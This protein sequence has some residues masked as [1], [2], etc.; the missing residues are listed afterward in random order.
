MDAIYQSPYFSIGLCILAFW[1]GL[2]IQNK[3]KSPLCNAMVL[4]VAFVI[5]VLNVLNISYDTFYI[6]GE[7]VNAFLVPAT[8]CLG[9]RIYKQMTLLKANL[10]PVL[11]G[12]IVGSA[13]SV[14]SVLA[15]CKFF[16]LDRAMTVSLLPKSV[17][18][19]IAQAIA[20]GNGGMVPIAV[21]AVCVTGIGGN[22]LAPLFIKLFRVK[23]PLAV[24][25]AIGASSHALGTAKALQIGE[26]EG[27]M[28]GLAMGLCG[29]FTAVL[30]L[31]FP[32]IV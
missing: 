19:P 20:D 15:L 1:L 10:L 28:S 5:I 7:M 13:T 18:T 14:F 11:V 24:G 4:A 3:T 29:V 22:L 8:A 32:Y 26:T 9:V 17:T 23:D 6:G 31:L 25:L 16:A 2:Q 27:A 12:C 30:A 21:A